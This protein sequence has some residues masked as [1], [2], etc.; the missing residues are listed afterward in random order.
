MVGFLLLAFSFI[1]GAVESQYALG[2][3][4]KSQAQSGDVQEPDRGVRK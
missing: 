3:Y 2:G 4:W 1:L